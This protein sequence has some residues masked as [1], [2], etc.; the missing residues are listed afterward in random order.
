MYTFQNLYTQLHKKQDPSVDYE[1]Q[2]K[3]IGIVATVSNEEEAVEEQKN[4][5]NW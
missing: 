3:F 1:Y 2:A 5:R 4:E